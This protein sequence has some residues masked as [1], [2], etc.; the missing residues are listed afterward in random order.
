[1]SEEHHVLSEAE[2]RLNR[3]VR[4]VCDAVGAFIEYWGFKAVHGRVWAL[5]ALSWRPLSQHE[6]VGYLDI[7]RSLVSTTVAELVAYGLVRPTSEHRNAPYE[8]VLDV[9]PTISDVLRSREWMLVETARLTLEAAIEEAE[10]VGEGSPWDRERMKMLL[11]MTELAQALLKMLMGA[12]VRA[13]DGITGWA[14]GV[15]TL[16]GTMSKVTALTRRG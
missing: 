8:A 15:K 6:I 7:S 14:K 3:R 9:W 11:T 1:M 2:V 16:L 13:L 12:R 5:L 10:L 4:H